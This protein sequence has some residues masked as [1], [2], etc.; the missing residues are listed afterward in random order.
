MLRN[1][2]DIELNDFK[3]ECLNDVNIDLFT[4]YEEIHKE[5]HFHLDSMEKDFIK[6]GKAK[7]D[8]QI[9]MSIIKRKM[10]KIS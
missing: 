9:F 2:I 5:S 7:F 3:V 10:Y 4:L 6:N 1:D 8:E